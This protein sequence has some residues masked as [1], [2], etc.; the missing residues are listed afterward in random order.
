MVL[1][2]TKYFLHITK[3][4]AMGC[5]WSTWNCDGDKSAVSAEKC[6]PIPAHTLHEPAYLRRCGGGGSARTLASECWGESWIVFGRDPLDCALPHQYPCATKYYRRGEWTM[7]MERRSLQCDAKYAW[8]S[9]NDLCPQRLCGNEIAIHAWR[10][11]L[12][13]LLEKAEDSRRKTRFV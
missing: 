11:G 5:C 10:E 13:V 4:K 3:G 2:Y 1:F 8:I 12:L 6:V 7:L 9:I